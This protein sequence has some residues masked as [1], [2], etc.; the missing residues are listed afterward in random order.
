MIKGHKVITF[1]KKVIF[2]NEEMDGVVNGP[3]IPTTKPRCHSDQ[4]DPLV[5]FS[6]LFSNAQR[7][8]VFTFLDHNLL[9]SEIQIS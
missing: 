9:L 5:I 6:A 2:L 8:N 4:V 7:L 3:K 1:A